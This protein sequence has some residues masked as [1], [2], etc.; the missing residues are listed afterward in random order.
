[1]RG[2]RPRFRARV[3]RVAAEAPL[4][5]VHVGDMRAGARVVGEDGHERT[6]RPARRDVHEDRG[7]AV[8]AA[9]RALDV[10]REVV[11]AIGQGRQLRRGEVEAD[12]GHLIDGQPRRHRGA[13]HQHAQPAETARRRRNLRPVVAALEQP[14]LQ[15]GRERIRRRMV[16]A[17]QVHP[18]AV[19]QPSG[20]FESLH[21]GDFDEVRRVG[22]RPG[23]LPRLHARQGGHDRGRQQRAETRPALNSVRHVPSSC[24]APVLDPTCEG[25][26][27]GVRRHRRMPR[28]H[29]AASGAD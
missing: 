19:G 2:R 23:R 3:H 17:M 29:G 22:Q 1:M 5:R 25:G 16:A 10:D 20:I 24:G 14:Y 27:A 12:G 26:P 21:L 13:A 6:E 8:V 15:R 28:R 18:V 4:R 7:R 11:H 9:G